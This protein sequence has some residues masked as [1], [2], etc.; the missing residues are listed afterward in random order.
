MAALTARTHYLRDWAPL[1]TLVALILAIGSVEPQFLSLHTLLDLVDDT[2]TLFV[3]ATGVAF[4]VMIGGIDL[5]IQSMAS[6]SSVIIALTIDQLG[7]GAFALALATGALSGW[8]AGLAHVKLRIPSFIATLAVGGVL[9]GVAL[10]IA[11]ERSI[12]LAEPQRAYLWWIAGE[13]GGVHHEI[14]IGALVLLLTHIVQSRTRFGRYSAAIGAG[15]AAA[16][17]SGVK[18]DRQKIIAFVLSAVFA[19]LAGI[20]LAGRL[21]SGSPTLANELLLPSIAAVVVGGTA[22]TGGVGNVWR[23][24]SGALILSVVRTGMTFLGVNIFAQQVVFG[25]VLMLAVAATI[26]RRKI[27]IV[28]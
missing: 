20:I 28:K 11:H 6:L 4:V 2:V 12:T 18:V 26:D 10:V 16:F 15:E 9:A 7:Y 25:I 1:L 3:L 21:A 5:S 27:P 19:A 17:A 22:I 24:L 13:S 14:V 23:T 8:S